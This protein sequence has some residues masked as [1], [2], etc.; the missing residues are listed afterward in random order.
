MDDKMTQEITRVE[1]KRRFENVAHS[2]YLRFVLISNELGREL[3]DLLREGNKHLV[4]IKQ[5]DGPILLEIP[6]T[7]GAFS[8]LCFVLIMR[9][10]WTTLV[11]FLASCFHLQIIVERQFQ[12]A[13]IEV[14]AVAPARPKRQRRR[15]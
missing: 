8:A 15:S 1:V 9:L 14:E 11:T 2:L 12:R 7:F 4:I 10:R 13:P 3:V 5:C 6:L